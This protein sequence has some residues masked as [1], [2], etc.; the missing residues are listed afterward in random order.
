MNLL[1]VFN[2]IEE[3]NIGEIQ[4]RQLTEAELEKVRVIEREV[5]EV[6]DKTE[7]EYRERFKI[8]EKSFEHCAKTNHRLKEMKKNHRNKIK[9]TDN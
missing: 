3:S 4:S 6:V 2:Q 8:H 1:D 9:I 7:K 5:N